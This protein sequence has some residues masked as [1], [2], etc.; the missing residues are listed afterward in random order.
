ME[1]LSSPASPVNGDGPAVCRSGPASQHARHQ[2]EPSTHL[3]LKATESALRSR[4]PDHPHHRTAM[5]Q[6]PKPW[7][8]HLAIEAPAAADGRERQRQRHGGPGRPPGRRQ[9]AQPRVAEAMSSNRAKDHWVRHGNSESENHD[10]A[11]REGPRAVAWWHRFRVREY[12]DWKVDL[13]TRRQVPVRDCLPK[14]VR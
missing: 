7:W 6:P 12:A 2:Q 8:G 13:S 11:S 9:H 1:H 10:P 3:L 5:S 4:H 14:S